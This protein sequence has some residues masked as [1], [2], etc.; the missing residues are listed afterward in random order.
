VEL[1]KSALHWRVAHWGRIAAVIAILGGIGGFIKWVRPL[2][3]EFLE[4][5]RERNNSRV[6]SRVM[7]ALENRS[8]WTG[9]RPRTGAGDAPIRADELAG[10]LSLSVDGVNDSLERL[11]AA[12][13]VR[14]VGGNLSDPTPRWH[15]LRRR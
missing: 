2:V 1:L 8:I 11:E 12:G 6:D 10:I 7:Q 3:K 4:W 14:N 9:P 5:R 15:T 13:R